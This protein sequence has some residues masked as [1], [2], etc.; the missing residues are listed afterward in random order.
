M[1]IIR[2][3]QYG[4]YNANAGFQRNVEMADYG[5]ALA[6]FPGGKGTEHMLREAVKRK[7]TIFD[8][9]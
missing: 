6:V 9:R 1:A 8:F 4:P 2:Y 7:L 5:D 3:N